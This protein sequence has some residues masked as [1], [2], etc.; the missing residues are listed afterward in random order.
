MFNLLNPPKDLYE[1]ILPHFKDELN[2]AQKCLKK[3]IEVP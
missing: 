2:E 1:V 3:L